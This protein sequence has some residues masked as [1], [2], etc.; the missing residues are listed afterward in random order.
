MFIKDLP[1]LAEA[2]IILLSALDKLS[3]HPD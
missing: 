2:N 3:Q 1:K